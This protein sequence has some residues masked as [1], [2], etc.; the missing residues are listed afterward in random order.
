MEI[1]NTIRKAQEAYYNGN[2]IMSDIEYDILY[3]RLKEI[4]PNSELLK[5][6]GSD[7]NKS[8]RKHK[9]SIVMGSQNKANTAEEMDT[10][11]IK[12][13]ECIGTLKLDGCSIALEYRDGK[14]TVGAT[15]GDRT[16]GDD[17][18]ENV[19]KMKGLVKEIPGFT[20]TVRGEV[21]LFRSVKEFYFPEMK[22]CRNAAAGIMK[23]L[24]GK[25]CDKLN[26]IV[27]DAQYLDKDKS[28]F[29]Q[30][31]LLDFLKK[32]GFSV[33]EYFKAETN[34]KKAIE[35]IN[36]IFNSERDYDIDGIVYKS[37]NIDMYDLTTELRP[38]Q[39][40]A[41]KLKYTPVK[42][43][44]RNIEWNVKN[45]TVTPVG[46]FD[47]VEIEGSIVRKASLCNVAMLEELGIEIGHEITVI[48]ANM[49]IP[50]IIADNTSGKFVSG[51][52][53]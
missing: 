6:V 23:H 26:I 37:N 30:E 13:P 18:T 52:E 32:S 27:Y 31:N 42:T 25:D 49:I 11:F 16:E 20:G 46:I 48:K 51:Y 39:M 45:E 5:S 41:L 40:I 33:V 38:K 12:Y 19:I 2:P 15:R 1:E 53:Y 8:F 3:D 17:I 7:S 36:E 9:H 22:N 29:T 14:F 21:L 24:D 28:F 4:N 34:G 44:L 10:F 47:P 43:I 50:K 35:R